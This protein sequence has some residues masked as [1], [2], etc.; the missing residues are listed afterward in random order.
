MTSADGPDGD[1][2]PARLVRLRAVYEDGQQRRPLWPFF[3]AGW[4]LDVTQGEPRAH[5]AAA[6]APSAL[7]QLLRLNVSPVNGNV[8]LP[9]VE[10]ISTPYSSWVGISVALA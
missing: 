8:W 10:Q 2:D 9:V 6:A 5:A 3:E 4:D 1:I 7:V